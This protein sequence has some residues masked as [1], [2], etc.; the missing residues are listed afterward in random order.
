MGLVTIHW[1]K[2]TKETYNTAATLLDEGP[3]RKEMD[4]LKKLVQVGRRPGAAN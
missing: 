4:N 2:A 3:I 1:Y